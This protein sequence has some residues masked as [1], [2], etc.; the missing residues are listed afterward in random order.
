[1]E[2]IQPEVTLGEAMFAC[3]ASLR[4]PASSSADVHG[5]VKPAKSREALHH[6]GRP[7]RQGNVLLKPPP[8]TRSESSLGARG[9]LSVL[10]VESGSQSQKDKNIKIS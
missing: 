4:A 2:E 1:M 9:S 8:R 3:E 7:P 5:S 6:S 10:V